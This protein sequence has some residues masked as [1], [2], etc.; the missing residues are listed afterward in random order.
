[1]QKDETQPKQKESDK[2]ESSNETT[3]F[4]QGVKAEESEKQLYHKKNR[5][6]RRK[7]N[8]S[9]KSSTKSKSEAS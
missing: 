2:I 4:T 8:K 9:K 3:T 5:A 1:M 6:F 7:S